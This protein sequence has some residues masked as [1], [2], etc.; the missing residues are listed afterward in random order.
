VTLARKLLAAAPAAAGGFDPETDITWHS[1]FWA[2]GTDFV[3]Q[4]YSDTD[5]VGTVP[6]ETGESDATSTTTARPLYTASSATLNNKPALS[7]TQPKYSRTAAFSVAPSYTSGVSIVIIGFVNWNS[8]A[9]LVD[10]IAASN[11]NGIYQADAATDAWALY[12]GTAS[13]GTASDSSPHLFVGKFSTS[14]NDL[15]RVDGGT[16]HDAEAGSQTLTGLTLGAHATLNT[17]GA[18]G[19]IALVG[20]YEGD[21]EA[22]GSW[23]SF[24]TWAE[25]HYGL[26]IA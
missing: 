15:L 7:W 11:R 24:E 21:I 26:T 8:T 2:E 22:D 10:G 14:G 3:A 16:V 9:F 1:L 6:N 4:G 17:L 13:L 5:P 18:N 25:T 19:D 12:A 23:S 20:V